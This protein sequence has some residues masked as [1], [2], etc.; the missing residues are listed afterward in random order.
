MV[1]QHHSWVITGPAKVEHYEASMLTDKHSAT[2][3]DELER[4]AAQAVHVT[5]KIQLRPHPRFVPYV[6]VWRN[7]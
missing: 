4:Y 5:G 2:A 1:N 3:F 7:Q 6:L